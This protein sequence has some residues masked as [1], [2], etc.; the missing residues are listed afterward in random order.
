MKPI[1]LS[2]NKVAMFEQIKQQIRQQI[3]QKALCQGEQLPSIRSLAAQLQ[4]GVITV[5]RAYEDLEKEGFVY[6][7]PGK[8]CFVANLHAEALTQMLIEQLRDRIQEDIAFCKQNGIQ[9][10][11]YMQYLEKEWR[12]ME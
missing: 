11:T 3:Y 1:M 6:T 2:K 4:V 7:Q 5:K 10:E 12:D 8:G 9:K